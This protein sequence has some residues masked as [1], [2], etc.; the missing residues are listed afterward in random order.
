ME[1]TQ[2]AERK[3]MNKSLALASASHDVRNAL[4][5]LT[6]LIEMSDQE[7]VHGS[8]LHTNLRLMHS[9]TKDLLGLLNSILD[10][11]KIEA[12]KMQLEEEE[13]DLFQFLED[14]VD[15]YHPVAME[16]RVDLILDPCNGSLLRCSQVKGDRGKLKQVLSNLVNN[17][18]K[19]TNEGHIAVRAWAQKPTL[20]SSRVA[21]NRY[22]FIKRLL[23]RLLHRKN[24]SHD[25]VEAVNSIQQDP[26][27]M[28]FTFEVVDTGI[29]IPKEKYKSVFENY[30]Q[31]KGTAPSQQQQGTGLG[32]GIVQSLVRL[33]HGDIGIV[34][35]D[36]GEKGTC[37]RF[38]VLLTVCETG[39]GGGRS[40]IKGQFGSTIKSPMLPAYSPRP[41]V[42]GVVLL[43]QDEE[44]QRITQRFIESLWI[45]VKV[46]KDW[47]HLPETL[48]MIKQKGFDSN[49]LSPPRSPELSFMSL[50]R[51][52]SSS[53][54]K[55]V[56]LSAMDGTDYINSFH[57]DIEATLGFYLLV[58]DATPEQISE[59]SWVVSDFKRDLSN[60][61]RVVWLENPLM[62][63][64]VNSRN[65]EEYLSNSN[66]IVLSKPFHGSRLLQ[67]I[68]LLPEY[69]GDWQ[70]S[71][72]GGKRETRSHVS[73]TIEYGSS[74]GCKETQ[75]S[76]G[77]QP[78]D[79]SKAGKFVVHEGEIEECE[80][81]SNGKPLSDM[82]ILVVDDQVILRRIAK[83]NLE[84]LGASMEECENG[85][86]AVWL[87]REGLNPKPPF[88][89][90]L[91]DCQMP[92]MG[93][94]EATRQIREM[95][96]PYGVHIPIIALTANTGDEA[97]LSIE[98]GM[99][100]HLEK[101]INKEKLLE[102]ISNVCI[103]E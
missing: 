79:M 45:K 24:E 66:D 59:L 28:D 47:R 78:Y 13:F 98:A 93:G 56:S 38:N 96:R 91:M 57:S 64:G 37:F 103:K 18:V 90:I 92:V 22:S 83:A 52:N 67:V 102:A 31:V 25:D 3:S 63:D 10:A 36:I 101:P 87:V 72:S 20:K 48:M 11:S 73:P 80:D 55:G 85:E 50:S 71:S 12:G 75:E 88:D 6:G 32:L 76:F 43:I 62:K 15:F 40:T 8:K 60:P 26:S 19:F 94:Y 53:R 4:A 86:Q 2:Q 7:V 61:Y 35:K 5:G 77:H 54:G 29:G 99:D 58:I 39:S 33:M 30:V 70:C 89:C 97:K 51:D 82:K 42:S 46:V 41:E 68:R 65:F 1:A 81:T 16:K 49:S 34:E 84:S 44:R 74:S 27:C 95:E 17:A 100:G 14:V 23:S 69:G 21:T 9:C